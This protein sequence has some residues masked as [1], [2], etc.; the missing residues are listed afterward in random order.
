MTG[1]TGTGGGSVD[2]EGLGATAPGLVLE[3]V[4]LVGSAVLEDPPVC[5]VSSPSS[6][7]GVGGA[8]HAAPQSKARCDNETTMGWIA[9]DRM[10]LG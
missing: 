1:F 3:V 6:S 9:G 8:L 10:T 5:S 2:P 4:E 7:I